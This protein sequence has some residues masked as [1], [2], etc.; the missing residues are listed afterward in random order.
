MNNK[1]VNMMI[2]GRKIEIEAIMTEEIF[3]VI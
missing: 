2:L 1:N 3:S